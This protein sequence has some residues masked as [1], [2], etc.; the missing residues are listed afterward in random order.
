MHPDTQLDLAPPATDEL[1]EV[2]PELAPVNTDEPAAPLSPRLEGD[3][4]VGHGDEIRA[5]LLALVEGGG[6]GS[7][8]PSGEAAPAIELD[9][10]GVTAIDTAGLQLLVAARRS[11]AN[12]G[13][14]LR[15]VTP[16]EPV[17]HVFDLLGSI[18]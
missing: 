11:A 18:Q 5:V 17:R 13:R 8:P 9:L 1:A 16:S 10:S 15:F 4:V 6:D 2:A 3:L 7:E 12:R 14:E